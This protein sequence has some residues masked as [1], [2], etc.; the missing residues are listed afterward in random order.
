MPDPAGP[1]LDVRSAGATSGLGAEGGRGRVEGESVCAAGAVS[2]P[3]DFLSFFLLTLLFFVCDFLSFFLWLC[4]DLAPF[5]FLCVSSCLP[6]NPF[7]D[8]NRCH[9]IVAADGGIGGFNGEWGD[10]G[11]YCKEKVELL[12]GEGVRV[13]ERKGKICVEGRVWEG[14]V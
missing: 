12:K 2:L 11:K 9:R 6:V 14:F 4:L 1:A 5:P 7:A 8:Y 13:K 10:T 3:R